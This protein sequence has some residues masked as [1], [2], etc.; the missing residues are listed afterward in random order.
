MQCVGIVLSRFIMG[1]DYCNRH[2]IETRNCSIS[3]KTPLTLHVC[4]THLPVSPCPKSLTITHLFFFL[5]YMGSHSMFLLD[6]A[7]SFI[8]MSLRFQIHKRF[9]SLKSHPFFL[10]SSIPWYEWITVFLNIHLRRNIWLLLG[11]GYH[12]CNCYEQLFTG[13]FFFC[14]FKVLFFWNKSVGV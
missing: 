1:V 14:R 2:Q 11:L 13:L 9:V 4:Y 10:L 3:V 8:T 6:P 5:I 7:F 12:K